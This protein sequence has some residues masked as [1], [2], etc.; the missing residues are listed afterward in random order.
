[1]VSL[2]FLSLVTILSLMLIVVSCATQP[3][4][5]WRKEGAT[6]ESFQADQAACQSQ[7]RAQLRA[8]G[9]FTRPTGHT[10]AAHQ[11]LR[12]QARADELM[13]QCME[14]AGY[15]RVTVE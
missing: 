14:A 1:M 3:R 2:R 13:L 9:D 6:P 11:Q 7:V 15:E 8:Q 10:P 12:K 4:F 5:T